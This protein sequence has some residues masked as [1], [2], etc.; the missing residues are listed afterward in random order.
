M[1]SLII[2]AAAGAALAV[3]SELAAAKP[4]TLTAFQRFVGQR[5]S[6][7]EQERIQ[8]RRFLWIDESGEGLQR[9]RRGE[10]VTHSLS[11]R[12]AIE[13]KGGLIH[14]WIGAAFLPGATLAR[15]LDLVKDY[16]NHKNIYPEVVG[17]R[18]L[19]HTGDDYQ[20]HLRLLKKKVITVVLNSEHQ[21]KYFPMDGTRVHSRSYSTR[22]AEVD[23]PGTAKERELPPGKDHGF[24]PFAMSN[25]SSTI[26]EFRRPETQRKVVP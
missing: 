10:V 9:V 18:T 23:H 20:I 16:D 12:N 5:E 17:S 7:I 24:L 15:T 4:E 1:R 3:E 6:A 26:R 22:I 2:I 11:G 14:D 25:A 8:G 13:V 21:V 19:R